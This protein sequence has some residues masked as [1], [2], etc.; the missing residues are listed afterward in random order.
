MAAAWLPRAR[1]D[2]LRGTG[3]RLGNGRMAKKRTNAVVAGAPE[4]G[5]TL[6][7]SNAVLEEIAYTEAMATEG[8][9]PAHETM[10]QG[11]LRRH[12]PHGLRAEVSGD[13][14]AFHLTLG[15]RAGVRI[16][17]VAATVRERIASA[18]REK[19]GY[20]VRAVNLLIDHVA[21]EPPAARDA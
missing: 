4:E 7:I 20:C 2:P 1:G 17:E 5:G 8:V 3:E 15:V 21:L 6:V 13:D 19:T 12:G 16:P 14:V 9:V 18:V 10:M 11:V